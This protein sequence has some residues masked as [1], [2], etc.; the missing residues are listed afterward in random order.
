MTEKTNNDLPLTPGFHGEDC[1]G[2]GL[3]EG[4]ECCC[5]ECDYYLCCFSDWKEMQSRSHLSPQIRDIE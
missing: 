1:L 5:D 2:N 4:V 3:Y